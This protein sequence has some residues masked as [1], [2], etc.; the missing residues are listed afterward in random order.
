MF[1]YTVKSSRTPGYFSSSYPT[2]TYNLSVMKS[3][4]ER[5]VHL[6]RPTWQRLTERIIIPLLSYSLSE[7]TR[8]LYKR[9]AS[10]H[11]RCQSSPGIE[12][13]MVLGLIPISVSLLI[14][15]SCGEGKPRKTFVYLLVA[16]SILWIV[17]YSWLTQFD[18]FDITRTI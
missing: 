8:R 12:W 4:K 17:K 10:D 16:Q 7:W 15:P 1:I 6:K 9:T 18:S 3:A 13:W 2:W 5:S 14:S 11:L